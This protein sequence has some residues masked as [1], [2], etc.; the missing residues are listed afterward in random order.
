MTPFWLIA[1]VPIPV[2]LGAGIGVVRQFPPVAERVQLGLERAL[3]HLE[4]GEVKPTHAMPSTTA[5]LVGT[6]IQEV[7]KA[8]KP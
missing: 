5:S 7:R 1:L 4:R 3:D 2:F 8:L 6:V